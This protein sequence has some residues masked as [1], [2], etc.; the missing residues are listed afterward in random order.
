MPAIVGPVLLALVLLGCLYYYCLCS[1]CYCLYCLRCSLVV[2]VIIGL[3][4]TKVA[5]QALQAA[6]G[7][8]PHQYTSAFCSSRRRHT[9]YIGDWSSDVCSSDLRRGSPAAAAYR[10][11]RWGRAAGRGTIV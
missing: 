4:L 6:Q 7:V 10:S 2:L 3:L 5:V 9:R 11:Q 8:K 1:L